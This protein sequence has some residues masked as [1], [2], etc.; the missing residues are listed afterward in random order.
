MWFNFVSMVQ[1][2]LR[3]ASTGSD[4][5]N[6]LLREAIIHFKAGE[7][8][9]ARRYLERALEMADDF[10][11]RELANF[12]LGV[13]TEDPIQKRQHFEEALAINPSN[14]DARR[15]LAILD[16]KLKPED[17]VDPNNLPAQS[18]ETQKTNASRFA[19]PK[20]GSRMVFAADGR[21]LM[22]ESCARKEALNPT[23]SQNEQDFVVAMATGQGHRA[24]VAMKT[25]Q[26][27]GC[28]A[29]F[30]L[31]PQ[32]I[33]ESCSYCGSVYVLTGARELVEP[34]SIIPMSFDQRQ[35]AMYLV[36][37]VEKHKIKPE[38]KVQAPRG[39]YLP[40][41]T[42]DI[43]GDIPWNGVISR[44]DEAV[45]VSGYDM[46]NFDDIVVYGTPKLADLLPHILQDFSLS[47]SAAYDPRYL[48]GWP[49]EIYQKNMAQA[50]L[51]ARQQA[52]HRVRASIQGKYSHI[53]DLRYSTAALSVLS[54][55]LVLVPV[56]VTQY[57]LEGHSYR[58]VIGGQSGSVY[59]EKPSQGLFNWLENMLDDD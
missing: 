16:G 34:D 1:Q 53:S 10:T 59:G 3:S 32:V 40:L 57:S 5:D 46:A 35:A 4:Y 49:A 18:S 36:T 45:P 42:F 2:S 20:C 56:W 13:I 54:F 6:Y 15:A 58:V 33:S 11:T 31:P 17:I 27:Q 7:L 23:A 38:G 48:A 24:P 21:T 50:S 9:T 47:R 37:W 19:C 14:T 55:K 25:F 28:G 22:C 44:K 8:D 39:L 51:E 29:Q 41:W 12:Y 30:V 26:C 52:A 43:M